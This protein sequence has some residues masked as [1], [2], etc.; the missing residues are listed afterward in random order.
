M[1]YQFIYLNK[2]NEYVGCVYYT[3]QSAVQD[4]KPLFICFTFDVWGKAYS[5]LLGFSSALSVVELNTSVYVLQLETAG[6]EWHQLNWN[7]TPV[8]C[9]ISLSSLLVT[10]AT[11]DGCIDSA[12][13]HNKWK[14]QFNEARVFTSPLFEKYYCI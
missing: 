13:L 12:W 9:L 7:L 4:V 5:W 1:L 8:F 2:C 6:K 14:V 3:A 10:W 11:I